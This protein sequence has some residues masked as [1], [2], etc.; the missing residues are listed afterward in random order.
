M[1]WPHELKVTGVH[2][3]EGLCMRRLV[4]VHSSQQTKFVSLFRK[5]WKQLRHPQSTVLRAVRTSKA[6]QTTVFRSA[7]GRP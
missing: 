2:L 6:M 4:A 7:D 5:I 3:K 1:R